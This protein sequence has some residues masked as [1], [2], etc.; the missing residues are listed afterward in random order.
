[1]IVYRM[2]VHEPTLTPTKPRSC[3]QAAQIEPSVP[4]YCLEL[5][6]APLGSPTCD[7]PRIADAPEIKNH[8]VIRAS[9]Q[10]S[11]PANDR[12]KR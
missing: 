6:E 3:R 10:G 11:L 1:M 4:P 7:Q 8:L 2:H 5:S 9:Q 12:L